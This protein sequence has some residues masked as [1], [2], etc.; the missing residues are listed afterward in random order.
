MPKQSFAVSLRRWSWNVYNSHQLKM[1]CWHT[2]LQQKPQYHKQKMRRTCQMH[3]ILE[4]SQLSMILM[5][6]KYTILCLL[7]SS[8]FLHL[9]FGPLGLITHAGA[10]QLPN[11]RQDLSCR[12]ITSGPINQRPVSLK[13]KIRVLKELQQ[14]QT[15]E[16]GRS[17]RWWVIYNNLSQTFPSNICSQAVPKLITL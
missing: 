12:L 11:Q 5:D 14:R 4:F 2:S 16:R 1:L 7:C 6:N 8:L 9:G 15:R 3:L 17:E 10:L 13:H